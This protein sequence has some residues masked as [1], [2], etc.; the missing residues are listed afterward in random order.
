MVSRRES[1]FFSGAEAGHRLR[2]YVQDLDGGLPRPLTE[3]GK[4]GTLLSPDGKLIA[5]FD[6]YNE[7]YLCPVGGGEPRPVEGLEDGDGLLEWSADGHSLFVRAAAELVLKIYKL[8][9]A[10]GRR[11]LWKELKPADTEAL[12][13]IGEDA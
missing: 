13:A 4:V 5:A 10:S 12:I 11:E 9:L 7:Y 3:E 8:D 6:R 2:S 1:N